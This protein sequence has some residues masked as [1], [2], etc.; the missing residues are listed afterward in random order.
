MNATGTTSAGPAVRRH[1]QRGA[2]RSGRGEC[3]FCCAHCS[4]L[5]IASACRA[6]S[7]RA[8]GP[9]AIVILNRTFSP[10]GLS[11]S[12][13]LYAIMPDSGIGGIELS[14]LFPG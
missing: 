1:R 3:W 7:S 9:V 12:L 5:L 8:F 11:P 14:S 10:P 2:F 13:K 4:S 6:S